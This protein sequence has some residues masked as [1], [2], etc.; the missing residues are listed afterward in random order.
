MTVS[1]KYIFWGETFKLTISFN[2]D[3][4]AVVEHSVVVWRK[5]VD[6]C[7][8]ACQ[9]DDEPEKETDDSN[10]QTPQSKVNTE[11]ALSHHLA[12]FQCT[13]STRKRIKFFVTIFN[14]LLST[15]NFEK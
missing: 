2:V 13:F 6:G 9:E 1:A 15:K 12:N 8:E 5:D 4:C 7:V 3:S 10:Y 14:V 11:A